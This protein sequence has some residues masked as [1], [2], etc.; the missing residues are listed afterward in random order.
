MTITTEYIVQEYVR[1]LLLL[2]HHHRRLRYNQHIYLRSISKKHTL[3]MHRRPCPP[4]RNHGPVCGHPRTRRM[5]HRK[6][7]A[8]L[9]STFSSNLCLRTITPTA[10]ATATTLILPK[11]KYTTTT[12]L[13]ME[14]QSTL[15]SFDSTSGRSSTGTGVD[16]LQHTPRRSCCHTLPRAFRE[17]W[18]APLSVVVFVWSM[19]N[20]ETRTLWIWMDSSK[21]RDRIG[22]NR[23]Q[24]R[25]I[26][27]LPMRKM[28]L[29]RVRMRI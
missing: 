17:R 8:R 2:H 11:R 6:T 7:E 5:H 28:M 21:Q 12:I 15:L 23:I 20:S 22:V 25:F 1:I 14:K 10:T 13:I 19:D 18:D 27:D 9:L 29:L 26:I 4:S 3:H 16:V 24:T